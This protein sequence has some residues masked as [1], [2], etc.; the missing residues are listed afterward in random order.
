MA[1][2]D[3]LRVASGAGSVTQHVDIVRLG[4]NSWRAMA[5]SGLDDAIKGVQLDASLLSKLDQISWDL[6]S[7]WVNDNQMLDHGSLV[8]LLHL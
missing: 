4:L 3:T 8:L 1:Q 6:T 2:L 7:N 5:F